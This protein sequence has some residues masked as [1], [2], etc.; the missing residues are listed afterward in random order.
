MRNSSGTS[1]E[2]TSLTSEMSLRN[3]STIMRFSAVLLVGGRNSLS[4][5]SSSF[6][7]PRGAVPFIGSV[8]IQPSASTLKNSSGERD[9]TTGPSSATS[10]PWRTG[11]RAVSASNAASGSPDHWARTGKVRLPW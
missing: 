11:W 5:S 6:V 7:A 9:S 8:S 2:P 4:R 10:A 1:S 3:R